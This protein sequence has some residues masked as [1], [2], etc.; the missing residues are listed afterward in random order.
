MSPPPNTR[1]YASDTLYTR[2]KQRVLNYVLSAV[3]ASLLLWGSW[4]TGRVYAA[5]ANLDVTKAAVA[6]NDRSSRERDE[7][8]SQMANERQQQ[9]QIQLAAI[10]TQLADIQHALRGKQ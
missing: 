9:I 5:D 3:C 7:Q 6:A 4:V 8:L 1:R 10:Q 2:D